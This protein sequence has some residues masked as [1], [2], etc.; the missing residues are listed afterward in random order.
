M[1][2]D[3]LFLAPRRNVNQGETQSPGLGFEDEVG[4]GQPLSPPLNFCLI[5]H[6]LYLDKYIRRILNG[7][8]IPNLSIILK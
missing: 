2:A 8:F 6:F 7:R 1:I 4:Y 5:L 3:L